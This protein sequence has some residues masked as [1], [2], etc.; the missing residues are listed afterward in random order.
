ML[1]QD[2]CIVSVGTLNGPGDMLLLAKFVSMERL[3]LDGDVFTGDEE[4]NTV[5]LSSISEWLSSDRFKVDFVTD[6]I[7]EPSLDTSKE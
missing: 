4:A 5:A 3:N 7:P 6:A 2:I 1:M